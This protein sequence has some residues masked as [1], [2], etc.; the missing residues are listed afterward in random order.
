MQLICSA[1]DYLG[2]GADIGGFW[3]ISFN[4]S[5]LNRNMLVIFSHSLTCSPWGG[6][7]ILMLCGV[8]N[9]PLGA[10]TVETWRKNTG[11][12]VN[13]CPFQQNLWQIS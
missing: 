9:K 5:S 3:V 2:F 10:T 7:G 11:Q 12:T 6:G 8:Y 1:V 4:A 13:T